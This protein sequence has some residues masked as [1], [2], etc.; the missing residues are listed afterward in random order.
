MILIDKLRGLGI[1]GKN[2]E[3]GEKF[4]KGVSRV[5]SIPAQVPAL[6]KGIRGSKGPTNVAWV[7]VGDCITRNHCGS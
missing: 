2:E 1:K 6:S 5:I 4:L 7:N 3:R